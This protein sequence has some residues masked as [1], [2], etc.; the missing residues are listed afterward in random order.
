MMSYKVIDRDQARV[1][2]ELDLASQIE[3]SPIYRHKVHAHDWFRSS[4]LGR[5]A[6]RTHLSSF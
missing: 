3:P 4:L 6:I 1:M 2:E 5:E